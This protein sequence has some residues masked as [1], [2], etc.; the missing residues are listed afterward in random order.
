VTRQPENRAR[1]P[2]PTRTQRAWLAIYVLLLTV[3]AT[4][5][6]AYIYTNII[7]GP[8][9][10][11]N[12]T[13]HW[14]MTIRNG[15]WNDTAHNGWYIIVRAP[16]VMNHV[17]KNVSISVIWYFGTTTIYSNRFE[18]TPEY[19]LGYIQDAS[20]WPDDQIQMG[21]DSPYPNLVR[22]PGGITVKTVGAGDV[23]FDCALPGGSLVTTSYVA[24]AALTDTQA[25][26]SVTNLVPGSFNTLQYKK[27]SLQG[28]W[29]TAG[30]FVASSCDTNVKAAI[31]SDWNSIYFRV[32]S[33]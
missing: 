17:F 15:T 4:P 11:P 2:L 10:N 1:R 22:V 6:P 28:S 23:T 20:Q 26:F 19:E 21:F 16:R 33:Q 8:S 12:G 9:M 27:D 14:D 29:Q 5:S 24:S 25:L 32:R 13:Y 30:S 3:A 7:S 18:A 31:T